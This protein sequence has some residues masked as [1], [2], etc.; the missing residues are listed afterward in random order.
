MGKCSAADDASMF[1][2][3]QT[4]DVRSMPSTWWEHED[5][6]Y[7]YRCLLYPTPGAATQ[8]LSGRSALELLSSSPDEDGSN[9]RR[10]RGVAMLVDAVVAGRPLPAAA[11]KL[12]S[13]M[14]QARRGPFCNVVLCSF[15]QSMQPPLQHCWAVPDSTSV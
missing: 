1:A 10:A 3:K 13:A 7:Q 15:G 8:E 14:E 2:A 4:T 11:R 6:C 12:L 9:E 5:Q